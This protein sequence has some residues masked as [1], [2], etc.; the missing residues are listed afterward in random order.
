M[1]EIYLQ[2]FTE[3]ELVEFTRAAKGRSARKLA[4]RLDVRI[5]RSNGLAQELTG[6]ICEIA[7]ARVFGCDETPI[8]A[9]YGIYGDGGHH[10][11][12]LPGTG[13]LA[14]VKGSRYHEAHLIFPEV[15]C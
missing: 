8:L 5:N 9:S 14:S 2:R 6:V 3:P 11:L 1:D 10:D 12:P 15:W 4:G 7:G 13:R